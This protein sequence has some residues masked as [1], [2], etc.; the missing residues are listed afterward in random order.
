[1]TTIIVRVKRTF[2]IPVAG[3]FLSFQVHAATVPQQQQKS[4]HEP[5]APTGQIYLVQQRHHEGS[6][7]Q[8]RPQIEVIQKSQDARI[9]LFPLAEPEVK[10]IETPVSEDSLD[11]AWQEYNRHNYRNALTIF[12]NILSDPETVW[13]AK[14]GLAMCHDK[15]KNYIKAIQLLQEIAANRPHLKDTLSNL[16]TLLIEQGQLEQ[17]RFQTLRMRGA[18]KSEW[19]LKID[20]AIFR[21]KLQEARQA[22]NA[23]GY[24]ALTQEYRQKLAACIWPGIFLELGDLL[25]K[26]GEQEQALETYHSLLSCADNPDLRIGIYNSM[27]PLLSPSEML[28]LLENDGTSSRSGKASG[29]DH[30]SIQLGAFANVGNA[31][32]ITV[33]MHKKGIEVSLIHK[34]N[35][36]HVVRYGD[37]PTREKAREAAKKLAAK[38]VIG[39]YFI[40]SHP[41]LIPHSQNPAATFHPGLISA[42]ITPDYVKKISTLKL[43]IL[44]ALLAADPATVGEVAPKI[45]MIS[46]GDTSA[47]SALAWW[48]FNGN[49]YDNAYNFFLVLHKREPG[50]ENHTLGLMYCL[51]KFKRFDEALKLAE[52]HKKSEKVAAL[53]KQIKLT[54]LWEKAAS[55]GSESAEMEN[56]AKEILEINPDD[57]NIKLLLAWWYFGNDNFEKSSEAFRKLYMIDPDVND[58]SYGLAISLEKLGHIDEAIAVAERH[59]LEDQRSSLLLSGMYL[60]KARS[61]YREKKYREAQAFAEK[62][63][64]DNPEDANARELLD[65]YKYKQT[66]FSKTMSRIEGLY[67]STYGSIGQDLLGSTGFAV[68]ASI[69]QGIDWVRLPGDITFSTY[70]EYKYSTRTSE[71][72]Y[73]DQSGYGVGLE[74][75]KSIF[76]FG[77]EYFWDTYTQRNQTK[78]TQLLYLSWF[79]EWTKRIW[80]ADEDSWLKLNALSGSTYG[81]TTHDFSG[82]TGTSLSGYINQGIDWFTLPGAITFNTYAEYRLSFRTRDTLFYNSHGP[83]VGLEFQKKPFTLGANYVWQ[84]YPERGLIDRQAGFY[85]RWFYD[86]D[87]KPD[88]D[89]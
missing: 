7:V 80:F 66:N 78:T 70:A 77:A 88:R 28:E 40:T 5:T 22:G 63:Q 76:K 58:H 53:A 45:L 17:A 59:R 44:H 74:F 23:A 48:N 38:Q 26:S 72:R 82:S 14:Y 16:T 4:D 47:H 50:N 32:R 10:K 34:E 84:M 64:A 86:W 39:S 8:T 13:E 35:G 55:A 61:A 60:D 79:D 36:T 33:E 73:F 46:P 24:K 71:R 52:R 42:P 56:L 30:Y 65:L 75:R 1:M 31:R 25:A 67:G 3:I 51:M 85:L 2:L 6:V 21:K 81:K 37:F 49:R 20:E 29:P 15:L 87:L 27:R 54:S 11:V 69:Q 12:T 18:Q 9:P 68:S 57:R 19:I 41:L 89:R 83:A 62:A 43:D